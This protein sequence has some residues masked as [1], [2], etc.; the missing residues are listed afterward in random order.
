MS[1]GG[2][3]TGAGR[4]AGVPNKLTQRQRN[5][6]AASGL[7]P[8]E[9]MLDVMRDE[10]ASPT[11]RD[12]MAKAAAPFVHPKTV[13]PATPKIIDLGVSSESAKTRLAELIKRTVDAKGWNV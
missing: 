8:L 9:Y 11:R 1:R 13:A 5:E 12:E 6:I 7:T 2:K 10:T 3:R 4:K